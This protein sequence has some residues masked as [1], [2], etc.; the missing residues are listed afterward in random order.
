MFWG[1]INATPRNLLAT[2]IAYGY[3]GSAV[4]SS[5]SIATQNERYFLKKLRREI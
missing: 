4:F 1:L 3:S 5:I 2:Y